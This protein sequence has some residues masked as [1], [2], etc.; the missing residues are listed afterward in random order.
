MPNWLPHTDLLRHPTL[1]W[2]PQ[3]TTGF[4]NLKNAM[5]TLPILA[6]PNFEVVFD[7]TTDVSGTGIG[8]VLSQVEKPIAFFSKK[9]CPYQRSLKHLLTQV[10]QTPDQHK[11]A[12]KLLGYDFEVFY[13]PGKE[14][15]VADALSRKTEAILMTI[16]FPTFPWVQELQD[17]YTKT[18]EGRDWHQRVSSNPGK[19]LGYQLH[20]GLIFY[21]DR[22]FIPL[23]PS[24][25]LKLLEEF[26]SYTMGGH[27]GITATI[28]Q[29]NASFFW[30]HLKKEVTKFIKECI[31]CQQTKYSTQ[32][33]YGLL[34]ALP[35]PNQVWE[36]IS[37]DFITHLPPSN[38][39]TSIWV[40]VDRLTKFSH[41]ITL[42]SHSTAASLATL[43][44]QQIYRLHGIPKTILSDRDP[45]FLSQFWKELFNKVGTK[46]LHS[47]A[48]HPKTD[49]QTEVVNRCLE[50]YLRC[51]ASDEPIH[52]SKYI[53]LAEYWYNTSYHSAIQ[54]TPFQALYGRP[55]PAFPHYT[56]GSSKVESI[57][58]T[59]TM[60]Q[61]LISQLKDTLQQTR[62]RMTDQANKHRPDKEFQT[63]DLVH[64]KLRV[65]RQISVKKRESNKLCKRY[66]GPFKV[67]EHVGKV[68]YRLELPPGSKVHPVFHISLLRPC[69]GTSQPSSLPL[70]TTFVED[71]PVIQ[72]EA[73]LD[74]RTM[75]SGGKSTDQVLV[76]WK[77][78]DITEATWEDKDSIDL[79]TVSDLADKVPVNKGGIDTGKLYRERKERMRRKTKMMDKRDRKM[80]KISLPRSMRFLLLLSLIFEQILTGWSTITWSCYKISQSV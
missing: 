58:S 24:P 76:K 59:L 9:L 56:M 52:W 78:R 53:Y 74:H 71:M 77:D 54:M 41:F 15:R 27:S 42:P 37:M 10:I 21:K 65:Y 57:D 7:V 13:N 26:H 12:A 68:A 43:F 45:I 67:L 19:L 2:T 63:G 1:Q 64:L 51:F 11:W 29:I 66:F 75:R 18:P 14:N 17:Y 46:L 32:Q 8:A 50:T 4:E 23:I 49:G 60:H 72:P 62:Q 25:R 70:P 30:P 48:Y 40:I 39:K 34:Q 36:E 35:I 44:L 5:L 61:Q 38:G 3:A 80:T 73:I 31:T 69:H 20:N 6:L 79:T 16:S 55:P 28:H 47:S 33:P 22:L